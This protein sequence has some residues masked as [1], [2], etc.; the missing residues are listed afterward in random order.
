MMSTLSLK[1]VSAYRGLADYVSAARPKLP[2]DWAKLWLEYAIE[3]YWAEWAQG[4]FNETRT[5]EQLNS[6]ITSL[7]EL[8]AE[9]ECLEHS[10]IEWLVEEAYQKIAGV[11]PSPLSE[12]AV[13]IY[14]A[15]PENTWLWEHGVVGT[16]IG[17]NILLQI[18]PF[19]KDWPVW[20]PYVLAHEYHHAV[21]GY[22]Y[23]VVRGKAHMDLLTGL[24][25]DGQADS[26]AKMLYPELRPLWIDALTPVQE[27]EQWDKMQD[28]LTGN[29]GAAYRRFFFGDERSGTPGHTAY[30]IGYHIVQAYLAA[31]PTS[32]VLDL[33]DEEAEVILA[34]SGYR[35]QEYNHLSLPETTAGAT[36]G[37]QWPLQPGSRCADPQS[38]RR[39]CR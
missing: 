12:R 24:V 3:P 7:D 23:F 22:N 10:G 37:G 9:V 5:R 28:H 31:H 36:P 15:D 27:A 14:A 20:V 4:Q 38:G 18:N 39:L 21:W 30:T 17:D 33:M 25:I 8:M 34:E 26:F 13:C 35:P 6:P 11:L 16:G 29:D 2:S 19:A 32:T 1:V